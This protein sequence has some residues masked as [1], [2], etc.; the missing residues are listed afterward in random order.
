MCNVKICMQLINKSADYF[1]HLVRLNKI[2]SVNT[3]K[4]VNLVN[5]VN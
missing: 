5:S 4:S 1:F 2:K 3:V